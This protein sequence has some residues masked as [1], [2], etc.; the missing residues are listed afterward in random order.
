[1]EIVY[2]YY[3]NLDNVL[4]LRHICPCKLS[5]LKVYH[6]YFNKSESHDTGNSR[7]KT[8]SLQIIWRNN[9]LI[10]IVYRGYVVIPTG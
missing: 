6:F 2:Y 5:Q 7:E 10:I 1:M 8:N 9:S 3:I 4:S